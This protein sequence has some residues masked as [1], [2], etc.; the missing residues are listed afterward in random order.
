MS[1]E[2]S[3]KNIYLSL[4]PDVIVHFISLQTM[5]SLMCNLVHK[6]FCVTYFV[7]REDL[8]KLSD[9]ILFF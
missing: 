8:R 3:Q 4:D 9:N 7:L 6:L 1:N 5:K 2:I